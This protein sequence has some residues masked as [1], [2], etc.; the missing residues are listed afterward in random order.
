MPKQKRWSIKR[1]LDFACANIDRAIELL[2]EVGHEFEGVHP[3]HYD[4]F[5]GM[6]NA[7]DRFRVLTNQLRDVI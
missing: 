2:V 3:E 6:V 1:K 5:C 7:L 4:M